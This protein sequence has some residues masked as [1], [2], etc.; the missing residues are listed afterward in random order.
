MNRSELLRLLE[1]TLGLRPNELVG[2]EKLRDLDVWDSM[3]TLEV[4][5]M[6]DRR[7]GRALPGDSVAL[8][9]TVD[10]LLGLID[11]DGRAAA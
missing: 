8:C 2:G 9:Q 10:E 11:G 1:Q 6:V 4:I 7:F 3:A 5:A